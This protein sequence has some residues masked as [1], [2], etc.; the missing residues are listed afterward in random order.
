MNY[1][2]AP[3][4]RRLLIV[5]Y[6]SVL[7]FGV[8][9]LALFP[10]VVVAPKLAANHLFT[11]LYSLLAAWLYFSWF[12]V[13]AGQTLGMKTWKTLVVSDTGERISWKQATI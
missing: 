11:P 13:K 7:V 2:P 4:W 12:W 9:Y 5:I 10:I 1:I 8:M 6:D 3:L